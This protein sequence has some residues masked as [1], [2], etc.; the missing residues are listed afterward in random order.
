M[1]HDF[2]TLKI[3][4]RE[5][6]LFDEERSKYKNSISKEVEK[7][8]FMIIGGG[9]S[10]G[11]SVVKELVQLKAKKIH[12]VDIN[13]NNLAE[14]VREIRSSNVNFGGELKTYVLDVGSTEFHHFF[15]NQS[16]YDFV[17]NLSALK[18]VRSEKDPYT[19]MRMIRVNIL[20]VELL[21]ELLLQKGIR[22]FFSVSTDKAVKPASLMGASKRVME[23][24]LISKKDD[25]HVSSARF[26]NVA[27]SEG[28]LL[29]SFLKRIEKNQP[30]SVPRKIKRYFITLEESAFLCIFTTLFA[31][32]GEIFTMKLEKL[33]PVTLVDIAVNLLSHYGFEPF[34]TEDEREAKFR[35]S[36]LVKAKMWPVYLSPPDTTGE[37]EIEELYSATEKIDS[38]RFENLIV[39]LPEDTQAY[40]KSSQIIEGLKRLLENKNWSRDD[41]KNLFQLHLPEFNHIDTGKY[42]DDRM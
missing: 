11:R 19:L 31:N 1:F 10:I 9:G 17:L 20:N 30:I 6:P 25:L 7:A 35:L 39:V 5:N 4:E 26:V 28:S 32:S 41:I 13:E 24:L 3:I 12:V 18:H 22:R 16:P 36:E 21:M 34:F 37:K 29:W 42:L 14:L 33:K 27:F 23:L 2:D 8:S 40:T 38:K 15:M